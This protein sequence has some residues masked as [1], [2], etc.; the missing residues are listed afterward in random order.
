MPCSA[1]RGFLMKLQL[2]LSVW[3]S[4]WG[5]ALFLVNVVFHLCLEK[6]GTDFFSFLSFFSFS[7]SIK[8]PAL[9][10][11]I[12]FC[13]WLGFWRQSN[14]ARRF[15]SCVELLI[16]FSLLPICCSLQKLPVYTLTA[17]GQVLYRG[18]HEHQSN[19]MNALWLP[20]QLFLFLGA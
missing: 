10:I 16:A 18:G 5:Q 15:L 17:S 1:N 13:A 6:E 19:W 11:F 2:L 8:A 4:A 3:H 14:H 20:G 9:V 12:S 7:W